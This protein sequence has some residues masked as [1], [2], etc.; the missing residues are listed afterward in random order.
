MVE[1]PTVIE[2]GA[3]LGWLHFGI[4]MT[5]QSGQEQTQRSNPVLVQPVSIAKPTPAENT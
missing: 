3:R 5:A 4:F 1:A 2:C